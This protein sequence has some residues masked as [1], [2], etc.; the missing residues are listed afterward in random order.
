MSIDVHTRA[1]RVAV[2]ELAGRLPD[3]RG[4]KYVRR[5]MDQ[6]YAGEWYEASY[7]YADSL[8]DEARSHLLESGQTWNGYRLPLKAGKREG[9]R[10]GRVGRGTDTFLT[11]RS[12][13]R[14][15]LLN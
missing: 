10:T 11:A 9:S 4:R 3:R 14:W 7:Q 1:A 8:V 13:I 6:D 15:I 2:L 5:G 12:H